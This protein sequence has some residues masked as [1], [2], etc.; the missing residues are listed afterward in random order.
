MR[1]SIQLQNRQQRIIHHQR[2]CLATLLLALAL[3]GNATHAANETTLVLNDT[4]EPPYT[5][6]AGDGFLDIVVGE[7]FRRAGL[8]LK[9]VKLPAE[10]GLINANAG[11]EDGDLSRIAGL[12][13][14]YPNLVR[15][16]EKL[17]DWHFVAF[18]RQTKPTETSWAVLETLSVGHI[19]GWKIYEQN[20]KPNTQITTVDTPEQLFAMLDKN[21][22]DVALYERLL[23]QALTK[24]MHMTDIHVA[25]PPLAVRE[26][27]I[28]LNKRHADKVPA[29]AAALRAIKADGTYGKI[30]R[31]KFAA[32]ATTTSQCAAK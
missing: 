27:F 12:E 16:P 20:L 6:K 22:I 31:E 10:R 7:A 30:C 11:I 24:Q 1:D 2:F 29:I 21:R 18:T 19:K 15:V 25:E 3:S 9:L 5:T 14:N 4:N 17:V 23:G 32:L 13:K 28:Y 26:M 8:R